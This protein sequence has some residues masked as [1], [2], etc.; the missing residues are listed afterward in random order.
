MRCC[1]HSAT[2]VL[3]CSC[4]LAHSEFGEGSGTTVVV[5]QTQQEQDPGAL[6]GAYG[7]GGV[8]GAG[9][10]GVV[11]NIFAKEEVVKVDANPNQRK[12]LCCETYACM[13]CCTGGYAWF[14]K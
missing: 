8:S 6:G 2:V 1:L 11:S 4:A 10:D 3:T 5:T 9:V 12:D 14:F 13:W 7:H